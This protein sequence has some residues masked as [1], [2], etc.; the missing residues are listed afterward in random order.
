MPLNPPKFSLTPTILLKN[1]QKYIVDP[2]PSG[3]TTNRVLYVAT[4]S[5]LSEQ[6]VYITKRT[7]TIGGTFLDVRIDVD[8]SSGIIWK[9]A[10][11][12]T[13]PRVLSGSPHWRGLLLGYY[14]EVRIDVDFS[15]GI[16]WKSALT[17]TPP[18]VLSGSPHWR[19][20]LLGYYL[21]VRIDV[22]S[23]ILGVL[24]T[25]A[26]TWIPPYSLKVHTD[27]DPVIS[28]IR[29]KSALTRTISSVV[30]VV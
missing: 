17:W 23:P 21:E 27:V 16:I 10:L 11:T 6:S 4:I 3:F 14:L 15:S 20:F 13:P 5:D 8:S 2:P 28:G 26:L 22:D 12:W 24:W 25:S 9:S 1:S 29:K 30:Y 7:D 18:R 19:G